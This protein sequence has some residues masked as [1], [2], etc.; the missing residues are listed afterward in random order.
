MTDIPT[1]TP[2]AAATPAPMSREA[3]ESRYNEIRSGAAKDFTTRYL[4]GGL[5]E[6]AEMDAIHQALAP[7]P[8]AVPTDVISVERHLEVFREWCGGDLSPEI[9]AEFREQ[10][11]ASPR[12]HSLAVQRR[13]ERLSDRSWVVK[14]RDGDKAA[15]RETVLLNFIISKPVRDPDPG[16]Q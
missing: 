15:A 9:E 5:A 11:L 3:A 6:R 16:K 4:N 2:P 12:E 8:I 1:V 10:R 14:Y 7:A 13:G